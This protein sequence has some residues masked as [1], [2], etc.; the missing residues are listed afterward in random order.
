M[1]HLTPIKPTAK[2]TDIELLLIL[3]NLKT[4]LKQNKSFC[5][6]V[7]RGLLILRG[8]GWE[9]SQKVSS[10]MQEYLKVGFIAAANIG[11]EKDNQP[12]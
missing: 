10:T 2:G 12:Q 4:C 7:S 8:H 3:W 6:T 5:I 1:Q 9:M 11:N